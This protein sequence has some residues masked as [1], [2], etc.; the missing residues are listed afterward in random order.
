[1]ATISQHAVTRDAAASRA[2]FLFVF[3]RT[4]IYV[5]LIAIVVVEAFP[6]DALIVKRR[7]NEAGSLERRRF[8]ENRAFSALETQGVDAPGP[9]CTIPARRG[10]LSAAATPKH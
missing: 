8:A 1:M 4:L 6:R 5:L 3:N 2:Q 7:E 10:G 9:P